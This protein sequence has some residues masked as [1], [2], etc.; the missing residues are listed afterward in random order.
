MLMKSV[1]QT[2]AGKKSGES[3][4]SQGKGRGREGD[5]SKRA[6]EGLAHSRD[7]SHHRKQ[8]RE[9]TMPTT[10][11][12]VGPRVGAFEGVRRF[13][14][15]PFAL[16]PVSRNFHNLRPRRGLQTDLSAFRRGMNNVSPSSFFSSFCFF[17]RGSRNSMTYMREKEG[18]RMTC[19][20]IR[21]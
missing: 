12:G 20:R 6:S 13:V 5:A 7:D 3:E 15:R 8:R 10:S 14:S 19:K 4:A 1:L 11:A 2:I 9:Q 18:K 17:R 21:M 16:V